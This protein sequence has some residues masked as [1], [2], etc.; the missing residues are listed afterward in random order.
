VLPVPLAAARLRT[1]GYTRMLQL[2]AAPA[3]LLRVRETE[4]QRALRAGAPNSPAA[5]ARSSTP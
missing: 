2:G 4:P 3:L 5:T 1:R